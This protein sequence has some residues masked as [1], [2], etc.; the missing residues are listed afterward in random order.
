MGTGDLDMR[1]SPLYSAIVLFLSMLGAPSPASGVDPCVQLNS[2][3]AAL[4]ASGGILD[5]SN[6]SGNQTCDVTLLITHPVE[7]KFGYAEWTFNGNPGI[8][9]TSFGPVVLEGVGYLYSYGDPSSTGT[10]FLSGTTAP[11]ILDAGSGGSRISNIDLNGVGIGTF[12]FLGALSSGMVWT[13][14]HIHNFQYAGL[15]ALSGVNTFHDMLINNNGGDGIVFANDSVMD[16]NC[17]IALNGGVGVHMLLGGGRLTDVDSDHNTLH[18]IYLDGRFRPGWTGRHSYVVPTLI[19]PLSGN[20]GGYYFLSVNVGG[21]TGIQAPTWTQSTHA[22]VSDG[23]VEWLNVGAFLHPVGMIGNSIIGGLVDD[24]GNGEPGGFV[25]DNIRIEGGSP[26]DYSAQ[27]NHIDGTKILQAQV[28]AYAVTGIHILYSTQSA[29][30]NVSFLGGAWGDVNSGDAGGF[31]IENSYTILV[32]ASSS[33]FSARNP[34]K[35]INS[36]YAMVQGFQARQTAV[37][38][39]LL[40]DTYCV[41]VNNQSGHTSLAQ[42]TCES[43]NGYGRGIYNGG[44]NTTIQGYVNSTIAV[45]ADQ[46]GTVSSLIDAQGNA[47]LSSVQAPTGSIASLTAS[48]LSVGGVGTFNSIDAPSASVSNLQTGNLQVQGQGT[49]NALTAS[50]ASITNLQASNISVAGVGTFNA[51]RASNLMASNLNLSR[52]YLSEGGKVT[53]AGSPIPAGT[54]EFHYIPLI[55][56]T[57]DSKLSWSIGGGMGKNWALINVQ[58]HVDRGA[59]VVAICNPTAGALT[60]ARA[61]INVAVIH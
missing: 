3:I 60:P 48:T 31:V 14:V 37:S 13:G 9:I 21:T 30:S 58:P 28:T 59:V 45:P 35:I 55:G 51:L 61:T 2:A 43:N 11:L 42:I 12:G 27:W 1:Y 52:L 25:S 23:T 46:L 24:N 10:A 44:T 17:Q 29:I 32:N 7:I 47:T 15:I 56:V 34:I 8:G 53:T 18:G 20:P 57:A 26:T 36:A 38:Q 22:L 40:P 16:G 4:P 5:E 50:N 41:S 19:K 39:S 49:F 54:C 33:I 6:L